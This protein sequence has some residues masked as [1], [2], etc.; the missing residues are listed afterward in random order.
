MYISSICVYLCD[1]QHVATQLHMSLYLYIN[2]HMFSLVYVGADVSMRI[3]ID[4]NMCVSMHEHILYIYI[5]LYVDAYP[6]TSMHSYKHTFANI[7]IHMETILYVRASRG[8]HRCFE[9]CFLSNTSNA[10][11]IT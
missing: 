1:Y 9:Y 5:L 8:Y 4:R 6:C 3:C 7:H 2:L 10:M 11:K